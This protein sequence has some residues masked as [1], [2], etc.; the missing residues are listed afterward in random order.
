M[1]RVTRFPAMSPQRSP[2]VHSAS[3]Q[4]R[5]CNRTSREAPLPRA[6]PMALSSVP[7][8]TSAWSV[9]GSIDPKLERGRNL[10]SESASRSPIDDELEACRLLDGQVAGIGA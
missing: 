4:P 9:D 3:G 10:E 7:P 6:P 8:P 1:L 2:A 5:S